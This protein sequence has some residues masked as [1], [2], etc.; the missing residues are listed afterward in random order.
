MPPSPDLLHLEPE[1]RKARGADLERALT[2][3]YTTGGPQSAFD[4]VTDSSAHADPSWQRAA[5][6][7]Q[8]F[9]S[10]VVEKCMPLPA[11]VPRS[12]GR[13]GRTPSL[14][15]V[16]CLPPRT[17]A[18]VVFRQK[19]AR[20]LA[21]RPELRAAATRAYVRIAEWRATLEAS[22]V[23]QRLDPLRRRIEILYGTKAV[24]DELAHGFVGAASGLE[25]LSSW[26]KAVQAGPEYV[27]LAELLESEAHLA[28]IDLSIRLG[29][30]GELRRYEIVRVHAPSD[31]PFRMSAVAR[32]WGKLKL[33]V[34]GHRVRPDEIASR[35]V[36]R[37]FEGI[38]P[39][40][41]R[42]FDVQRDLDFYLGALGFRELARS[43]GLEVCL[44]ELAEPGAFVG[45]RLTALFDPLLLLEKGTPVPC[46]LALTAEGSLVIITG[47]N[48][49]GKT[50]LIE[51][52][53]LTQLLAHAGLWVPAARAELPWT[54]GLYA[55]LNLGTSAL[56]SEG[57]LGTELLRIRDLFERLE[58]GGLVVVDELCSGT[59]PSEG[60]EIFELVVGL[61]AELDAQAFVTTH[62]LRFASR[63]ETERP[64]P[65]L[66]FL[67]V[68]LDARDAPTYQFEPGVAKTSLARQTAERL[69]V[70]R[71]EIGALIKGKLDAARRE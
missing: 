56:H 24:F 59:N 13:P 53:G 61:L 32:I 17:H 30:D 14:T 21:E 43:R 50:R 69:G 63:L 45:R 18:G 66:A 15:A 23:G 46:D 12:A 65:R 47:P 29:R 48:S 62:F 34:L 58:V 52:I 2:F 26:A 57:S 6:A 67:Q 36:D 54:R 55:S 42:L 33:M 49:G 70:T 60:E 4:R 71:E 44:P 9:V 51:A 1:E 37:V 5:F 38:E 64:I 22:A 28:T 19:I 39:E 40:V 8:L 20:E 16:L 31:N 10:Q 7:E 25:R 68:A 27:R 35:L 3:A 41:S 11:D